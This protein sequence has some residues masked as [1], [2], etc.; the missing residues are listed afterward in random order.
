MHINTK[1][2]ETFVFNKTNSFASKAY[3]IHAGVERVRA[4]R[5]G[6]HAQR[7]AGRARGPSH[8]PVWTA[9][10]RRVRFRLGGVRWWRPGVD[11]GRQR[12]TD[13]AHAVL[14][15][16]SDGYSEPIRALQARFSAASIPYVLASL[17]VCNIVK[18]NYSI[19]WM[20]IMYYRCTHIDRGM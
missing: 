1:F 6:F 3:A 13:Y 4:R 16:R 12:G 8:C 14:F 19:C 5:K 10:V 15:E 9:R 17:F 7:P 2:C 20:S 11:F 18:C